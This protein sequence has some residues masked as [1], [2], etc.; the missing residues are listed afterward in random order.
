MSEMK[1]SMENLLKTKFEQRDALNARL[2]ESE[3]K[4]ERAEVGETLKSLQN[5]IAE[6]ERWLK[7]M[8]KP[9]EDAPAAVCPAA[10]PL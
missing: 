1:K 8:D 5:E 3:S 7:D 9:A 2:I 4:E 6:V 10:L